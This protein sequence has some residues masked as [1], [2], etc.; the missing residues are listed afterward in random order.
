MDFTNNSPASS[1]IR[2]LSLL[3]ALSLAGMLLTGCV[4]Q[5]N[6]NPSASPSVS[7]APSVIPSVPAATATPVI[8]V[9]TENK[10]SQ[11]KINQSIAAAVADGTYNTQSTYA[12]HSGTETVAISLSVA[13]DV[14]TNAS[15]TPSDQ[16]NPMSRRII[17]NFNAALPDL[18]VGKKI[19]Q[20]NIPHNVAGSSLTTAAFKAYVDQLVANHGV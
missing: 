14:V 20:L 19:D 5:P 12:Y 18:V 2:L 4:S 7:T 11:E 8:N 6:A 16:A 10:T 13:N 17:D 9:T 3:V 1:G 15:V